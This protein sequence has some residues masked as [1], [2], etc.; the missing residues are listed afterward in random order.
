MFSIHV[1]AHFFEKNQLVRSP[2]L[3]KLIIMITISSTFFNERRDLSYITGHNDES[4]SV[5]LLLLVP[6]SLLSLGT[7]I[8]NEA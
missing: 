1:L 7:Q 6:S 4:Y 3:M 5:F 8:W 2:V